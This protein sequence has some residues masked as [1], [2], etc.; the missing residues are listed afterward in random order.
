MAAF[1][2]VVG[3]VTG[4]TV[5]IDNKLRARDVS[6]TMPEITPVTADVQAMGTMTVPVWQLL[7]NLEMTFTKIGVDMGFSAC[8][9][10]GVTALEVR[11]TQTIMDAQGKQKTV[12]CKAFCRGMLS[13]IP[14]IGLEVGSPVENEIPYYLTRYQLYIDGQEAVLV[15]R[16]AGLARVGGETITNDL[17]GL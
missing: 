7:E 9:K 10:T 2:P 6:V 8:I 1:V 13:S 15:D 11:F 4:S 17:A 14:G 16:L 3:P 5:Y 12:L